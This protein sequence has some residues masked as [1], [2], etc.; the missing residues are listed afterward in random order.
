MYRVK[1]QTVETGDSG[2][3]TSR[4]LPVIAKEE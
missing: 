3:W 2:G 4:W 1:D